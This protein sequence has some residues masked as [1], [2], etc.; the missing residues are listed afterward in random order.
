MIN[1]VIFDMDGL[2][3]DTEKDL[4]R[5]WD[6]AM[7]EYGFEL[8]HRQLLDIRSMAPE[9]AYPMFS[10]LF[11]ERMVREYWDI[12]SH[13]K[14]LMAEYV[15]K[16]GVQKKKGVDRLLEYL[17]GNGYKT[18]VATASDEER[19]RNYLGQVGLY[20]KF[21]RILCA[22]SL[23]HGKPMPDV[24]LYACGQLHENPE[25]CLALEDSDNGA[26]SAHRAGCPVVMVKDLAEPRPDTA[27]YLYG[28]ADDLEG[29]IPM[30]ERMGRQ[31]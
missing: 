15:Q 21:D 4:Y 25:N 1:A 2:L 20:E 13:R 28:V 18:A 3:I 16:Y 10:E 7:R 5:C 30:L 11:G 22:A 17:Q 6:Q 19:T 14:Q 23:P 31:G 29:V 9:F 24:Y 27:E 26:L 8:T 12:R